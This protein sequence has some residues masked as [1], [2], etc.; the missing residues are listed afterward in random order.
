MPL[1]TTHTDEIPLHFCADSCL[2]CARPLTNGR[3]Y[4]IVTGGSAAKYQ[5]IGLLIDESCLQDPA[6]DQIATWIVYRHRAGKQLVTQSWP[7]Y[8]GPA[9]GIVG[10]AKV[11]M[12]DNGVARVGFHRGHVEQWSAREVEQI[13]AG[14]GS[15]APNYTLYGPVGMFYHQVIDVR[16]YDLEC[17]LPYADRYTST[18]NVF[19][20]GARRAMKGS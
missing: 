7:R 4:P 6:F 16:F 8:V 15:Y 20:T 12:L 19:I 10:Y 18:E 14:Y 11:S 2:R 3:R 5:T 17:P 1:T 9:S 13:G